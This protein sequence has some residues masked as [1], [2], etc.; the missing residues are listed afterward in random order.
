[1]MSMT[2]I[3]RTAWAHRMVREGNMQEVHAILG[4][5]PY[6]T[7]FTKEQFN[8]L[9]LMAEEKFAPKEYAARSTLG[10]LRE[11]LSTASKEYYRRYTS[12][13]PTQPPQNVR[14]AAALNALKAQAKGGR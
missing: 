5:S 4:G 14:S 2:P 7:G 12:V 6:V 13:I 3:D 10:K 1:M 11:S 9:R 8:E